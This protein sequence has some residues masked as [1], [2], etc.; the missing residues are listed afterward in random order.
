MKTYWGS[1]GIARRI[2]WPRHYMEKG[3]QLH[4]PAASPPGKDPSYALVGGWVGPINLY[5]DSK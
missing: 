1:E 4:A 3:G 5:S 2:I